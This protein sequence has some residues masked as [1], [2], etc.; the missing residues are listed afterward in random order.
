MVARLGVGEGRGVRFC[1]GARDMSTYNTFDISEEQLVRYFHDRPE[2]A[3]PVADRAACLKLLGFERA[4][5]GGGCMALCL[6]RFDNRYLLVTESGGCA[7]PAENDDAM[8]GE[9]APEGAA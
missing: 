4:H 6:A 7:I 2:N 8:V 9:Y 3:A 1:E 5:T